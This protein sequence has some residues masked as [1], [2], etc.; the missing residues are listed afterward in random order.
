MCPR[1]SNTTWAK[2]SLKNVDPAVLASGPSAKRFSTVSTSSSS[3]QLRIGRLQDRIRPG[4][5]ERPNS[6]CSRRRSA[7]D[8]PRLRSTQ[9]VVR[10]CRAVPLHK[11]RRTDAAAACRFARPFAVGGGS[12]RCGCSPAATTRARALPEG[13][14][15]TVSSSPGGGGSAD[16]WVLA[17]RG[18]P[19]WARE[20][21][22]CRVV[23]SQVRG[24]AGGKRA[25][26]APQTSGSSNSKGRSCGA[27]TESRTGQEGGRANDAGAE[28]P[29]SLCW[30]RQI[31]SND[32]DDVATAHPHCALIAIHRILEEF[33]RRRRPFGPAGAIQVLG[34]QAPIPAMP[35]DVVTLTER[36]AYD[37][38]SR[39]GSIVDLVRA[40]A[41]N[42]RRG[43]R[44]SH[45]RDAG[46]LNT[47]LQRAW[48]RCRG[49]GPHFGPTRGFCRM[50]KRPVGLGND[51]RTRPTPPSATTTGARAALRAA[52]RTVHHER[53]D[54]DHPHGAFAR[55]RGVPATTMGLVCWCP[56]GPTTRT[57][58]HLPGRDRRRERARIHVAGRLSHDRCSMRCSSSRAQSVRT[59]KGPSRAIS[60]WH[61][62][63]CFWG[64]RRDAGFPWTRATS[65]TDSRAAAGSAGTPVA[66]SNRAVTQSIAST[67]HRMSRGP[68]LG[69]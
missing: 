68:T 11:V 54:T 4:R 24:A 16:A 21:A 36:V 65:S 5:D 59:G 43:A 6:A 15:G 19:G 28:M 33:H 39:F 18:S 8:P 1:S 14:A 50:L 10:S 53:V 23:S 60:A 67:C 17:A 29:E 64:G 47:R 25:S 61:R 35:T 44:E 55:R 27:R 63:C 45:R 37:Q 3:N 26:P 38:D 49:T 32:A 42:A 7:N 58:V 46:C 12:N 31:T 13:L 20:L 57:C 48:R 56:R 52:A 2:P 66:P 51:L 69:W 62:R 30:D 41:A 9:P 22:R 40:R 34:L